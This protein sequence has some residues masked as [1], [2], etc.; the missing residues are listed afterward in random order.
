MTPQAEPGTA[1]LVV[2]S[3][4]EAADALA[5]DLR[6]RGY[7]A[8]LAPTGAA[9]LG[10]LA[11]WQPAAAV[12]DLDAPVAADLVMAGVLGRK[13]LLIA[14][15][16]T[17]EKKDSRDLSHFDHVFLK[18]VSPEALADAIADYLLKTTSAPR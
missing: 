5:A 10:L 8:R 12:L 7:D 3:D 11:D 16:G 2:H 15:L 14:L 1:V 13:A 6:Q 17:C 9:A 18:S 4:R